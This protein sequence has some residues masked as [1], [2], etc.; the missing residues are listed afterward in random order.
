MS[1]I[2]SASETLEHGKDLALHEAMRL[3]RL[4]ASQ[5]SV[6]LHALPRPIA[7]HVHDKLIDAGYKVERVDPMAHDPIVWVVNWT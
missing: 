4:N 6:Q 7:R 2:P 1:N 3:I 5:G